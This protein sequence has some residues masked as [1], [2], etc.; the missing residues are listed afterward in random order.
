MGAGKSKKQKLI[1]IGAGAIA[2]IWLGLLIAPALEDGL[3]KLITEFDSIISHPFRI[4]LCEKTGKT[5]LVL[6]M[7]YGVTLGVVLSNERNYRK[8]EEYG[9]SKWGKVEVLRRKY[10]HRNYYRNIILTQHVVLSLVSYDHRRNLNV[11]VVGTS[12]TGKSTNY[13]MENAMQLNT[14][15]IMLD[16]KG[17]ACCTI[18]SMIVH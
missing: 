14:S 13:V 8:L 10:A 18:S 3:L 2:V 12:G 11:M 7:M 17:K 16:P 1:M 4:L 6:L 15:Y 5:I 9:S